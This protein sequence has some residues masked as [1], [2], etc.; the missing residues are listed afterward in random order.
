MVASTA[1]ETTDSVDS[2]S[3]G[4]L[5]MWLF[6][7]TEV[8]F[9]TALLAAFVVLRA[10]SPTWPTPSAVHVDRTLGLVNTFVLLASGVA[11]GQS[12]RVLRSQ[13]T[14]AA[15]GWLLLALVL[16]LLFLGIKGF[17]YRQKFVHNLYPSPT[18]PTLFESADADYLSAVR[19]R[20]EKLQASY[21][22]LPAN[23]ERLA[24]LD[25]FASQ[26]LLPAEVGL[27]DPR[28]SASALA[29]CDELAAS[30]YSGNQADHAGLNQQLPW[31]QLPVVVPGGRLWTSL[32]FLLTGAHVLH[33]VVAVL[34]AAWWVL[35]GLRV[36]TLAA[37][38]NLSL[39]WHF[40][41]VV[42]IVLFGVLYWG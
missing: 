1:A 12:V 7:A 40:V 26:Q 6:I 9:F 38:G 36:S 4:R 10:A 31:L 16:G 35:V 27:R 42:W 17:E 5:G 8:M 11:V 34:V 20:V 22:E 32:Y 18:S 15:R 33:L 19:R 29:R 13:K 3:R 2:M 14:A 30:I 21:R 37:L 23:S 41:D 25:E 24:W 39:Y 28:P